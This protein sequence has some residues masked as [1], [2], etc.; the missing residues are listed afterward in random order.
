M[1][2][3]TNLVNTFKVNTIIESYPIAN[4]VTVNRGD[5]LQFSEIEGTV[6]VTNVIDES[7]NIDA[8]AINTGIGNNSLDIPCYILV[9][10]NRY[11]N[12]ADYPHIVLSQ[13]THDELYKVKISDHISASCTD[14]SKCNCN[15]ISKYSCDN[16]NTYGVRNISA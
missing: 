13:F 14:I 5:L 4:G 11:L 10:R 7:K 12:L 16:L 15:L 9:Y 2:I 6:Y 1:P 8:I 3:R